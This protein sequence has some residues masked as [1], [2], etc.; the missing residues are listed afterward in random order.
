MKREGKPSNA[1][2]FGAQEIEQR[3][4]DA[5]TSDPDNAFT[6]DDLC[7]HVYPGLTR[8]ERKH[9]AAV[10]PVA[11][12]VC[13]RLGEHWEW[14]R[15]ERRGGTLVFWNRV[16][17]TSYALARLKADLFGWW[18]SEE[19]LKSEIAPDGRYHEYVIEGGTWWRHCQEDIAKF[20][21]TTAKQ[22]DADVDLANR[23]QAEGRS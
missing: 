3:I 5:L 4:T 12:K 21:Q 16:S 11:K 22:N 23:Q 15:A 18:Q 20:R 13:E 7:D 2:P 14:W 1:K 17:V 6:T 19:E 9:R 8:A 10:V